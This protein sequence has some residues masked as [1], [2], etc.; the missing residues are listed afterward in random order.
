MIPFTFIADAAPEVTPT[1]IGVFVLI[2][3]QLSQFFFAYKRDSRDGQAVLK[4]D[5][6]ALKKD[7][8]KQLG[9]VEAKMETSQQE[10]TRAREEIRT[11]I[12]AV[13]VS[14]ATLVKGQETIEQTMI[15]QGRKIDTLLGRHS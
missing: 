8:Q 5:L 4:S 14:N 13:A 15:Y 9:K 12:G 7:F 11:E 3:I 6:E 10:S 1:S 2:A